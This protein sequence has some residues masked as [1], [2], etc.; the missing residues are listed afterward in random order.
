[1]W[2]PTRPASPPIQ[3]TL[4]NTNVT[5]NTLTASPGLTVQGGGLFTAFSVT[6]DGSRIAKNTPDQCYG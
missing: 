4:E 3:L 1:V 6:L 2:T 5:R